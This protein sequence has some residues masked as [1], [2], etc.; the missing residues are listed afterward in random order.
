VFESDVFNRKSSGEEEISGAAL[1]MDI[2]NLFVR[3]L[4]IM[5]RK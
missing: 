1:Y 2:I 5:G 3:I 4:R